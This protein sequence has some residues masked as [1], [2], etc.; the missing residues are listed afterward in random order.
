M[1][2]F[3]CEM[4]EER[5]YLF[6]EYFCK[7]SKERLSKDTAENICKSDRNENC[8]DY[9]KKNAVDQKKTGRKLWLLELGILSSRTDVHGRR[10][11]GYGNSGMLVL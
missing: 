11:I 6:P 2:F 1:G 4:L 5:G 8:D 9:K 3:G 10:G 7:F